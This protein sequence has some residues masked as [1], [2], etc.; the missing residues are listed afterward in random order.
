MMA[1]AKQKDPEIAA[2]A[3]AFGLFTAQTERLQRSHQEL[4]GRVAALTDE[5]AQKN[6]ELS[7][8]IEEVERLRALEERMHRT[9]R[10]AALGEMA[11]GVA[12]EIRNPLG[13]IELYAGLLERALEGNEKER[14]LAAKILAGTRHLDRIVEGMLAFTR[15]ME[16]DRGRVDLVE[17]ARQAVELAAG[18]VEASGVTVSFDGEDDV[19]AVGDAE[20]LR[21]V[22][23]NV[24]TNACQ[25]MTKGGSLRI[26][27]R[28]DES[29]DRRSAVCEFADTGPGV[30][31]EALD[32]VFNPFFT[33]R[34][35][36]TGLGLAISHRIVE[37]HGGEITVA[38][39]DAG[40][41]FTVRLEG[42]PR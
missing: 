11:A 2:L 34:E 29:S 10:L 17:V 30:P 25:A 18:A 28:V 1:E 7:E 16:I 3:E 15:E 31:A 8:Q 23:L 33:A 6:R 41:V 40:A 13:G 42:T 5:L 22:F 38:N 19:A 20:L 24:V 21:R 35:G 26:A 32:R 12:H 39:A 9:E 37:A 14:I 27:C 4:K 36:G